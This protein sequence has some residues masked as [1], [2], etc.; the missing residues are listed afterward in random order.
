MRRNPVKTRAAVLPSR[1]DFIRATGAAT[2]GL[3]APSAV[4]QDM[5]LGKAKTDAPKPPGEVPWWLGPQFPTSRVVEVCSPRVLRGA[6]VEPYL[7]SGMIDQAVQQLTHAA[8]PESAWRRI[9]GKAERIV[10][11]FNSVGASV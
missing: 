6:A 8:T 10:A 9:L 5:A 4:A 1:R 2:L 11:K 3:L 7:L